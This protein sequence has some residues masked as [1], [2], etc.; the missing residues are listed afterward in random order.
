MFDPLLSSGTN[1]CVGWS[2]LSALYNRYRVLGSKIEV[3]SLMSTTITTGTAQVSG[4]VCVAPSNTGLGRTLFS[5]AI[6]QPHAKWNDITSSEPKR[7]SIVMATSKITGNKTPEASDRT[8]GLISGAPGEEWYWIL[9][10]VS[11]GNYV[12]TFVVMD[13][14]LT[15]DVEFFDRNEIDRSSLEGKQIESLYR[16]ICD[17][18]IKN[19]QEAKKP[20]ND[21]LPFN[22]AK[23]VQQMLELKQENPK[24]TYN[25]EDEEDYP[26]EILKAKAK[27]TQRKLALAESDQKS[28]TAS[29]KGKQ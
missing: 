18:R 27:E 28:E 7:S 22:P 19:L 15:Y 12:T 9:T 17:I 26:L 3:V 10:Y 2:Q 8:Q 14:Q 1:K 5:D 23:N 4:A 29:K 20:H 21:S 16:Q 25:S 13:V 24:L 6:S 11:D